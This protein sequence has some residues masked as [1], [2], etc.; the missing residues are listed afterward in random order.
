MV[1]HL[2]KSFDNTYSFI[3][4]QSK[5]L[6]TREMAQILRREEEALAEEKKYVHFALIKSTITLI[7]KIQTS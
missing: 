7:T 6:I 2:T 4:R 1:Y 5:W 3:R